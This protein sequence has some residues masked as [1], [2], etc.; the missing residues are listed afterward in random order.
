MFNKSKYYKCY[1]FI[2][3]IYGI[4]MG[5]KCLTSPAVSLVV[6]VSRPLNF[7]DF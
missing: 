3:P 5:G 1:I 6:Q 2:I 7:F 4:Y